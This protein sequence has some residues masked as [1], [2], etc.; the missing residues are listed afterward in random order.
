M[1]SVM[2]IDVITTRS[3]FEIVFG[4]KLSLGFSESMTKSN[5]YIAVGSFLFTESNTDMLYDAGPG[6]LLYYFIALGEFPIIAP[7]DRL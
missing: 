2:S 5:I 3:C 7:G 1:P 6:F 4:R